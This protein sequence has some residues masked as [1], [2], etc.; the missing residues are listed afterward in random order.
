M[1]LSCVKYIILLRL[2][3]CNLGIS[4]VDIWVASRG[5]YQTYIYSSAA[6]S[7]CQLND[8]DTSFEA[9]IEPIYVF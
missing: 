1:C 8:M 2:C 3:T 9:Y 4:V 6:E 7:L 5:H